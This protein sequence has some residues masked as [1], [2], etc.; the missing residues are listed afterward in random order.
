MADEGVGI[1]YP[2]AEIRSIVD[3]TAEFV[4]RN[5]EQFE[6]KILASEKDNQKFGFLRPKDPYAAYYRFKIK[7]IRDA[8]SGGSDP[9]Q[10][11]AVPGDD[12]AA[13]PPDEPAQPAAAPLDPEQGV[14]KGRARKS[15]LA[16]AREL[17][18]IPKAAPP[19]EVYTVKV[20]VAM[21]AQDLDMIKLTAQ[22]VARNGRSFLQSL[23]QREHRSPQFEFLKPMHILV[24][25][26]QQLVDAYSRVLIPPRTL[27]DKLASAENAPAMVLNRCIHRFEYTRRAE[28][29]KAEREAVAEDERVAMQLIDWHDFVVVETLTFNEDG[30]DCAVPLSSA[31]L[32]ARIQRPDDM[33]M[34][35][36]ATAEPP[37]QPDV[38]AQESASSV[39][40][41]Q[42]DE[43]DDDDEDSLGPVGPLASS[44][45]VAE[46]GEMKI[47][48]DYKGPSADTHGAKKQGAQVVVDPI[49]GQEIRLDEVQE[50][51]KVQLMDP[52][53]KE[54]KQLEESKRKVATS[55]DS[56]DSIAKNLSRLSKK[57][58]D[59]FMEDEDGGE[60]PDAKKKRS[61]VLTGFE[62]GSAIVGSQLGPQEG[63][64]PG[65]GQIAKAPSGPDAYGQRY[66]TPAA[67][68][69]ARAAA[70]TGGA[71]RGMPPMGMPPVSC[72]HRCDR[73]ACL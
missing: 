18:A 53:W 42:G 66:T 32:L 12:D 37:A 50:H 5:G 58:S 31:D 41:D 61:M 23:T 7:E 38:P 21:T 57:R 22:F 3:K 44:V 69:P 54:K 13:K 30:S 63:G 52:L 8:A 29:E 45:R 72:Q 71:P 62:S 14:V 49:T 34:D 11:A 47:R 6:S 60:E 43:E 48:K 67:T 25:F 20:P 70:A 15:Q 46:D 55:L 2:P 33:D 10:T 35:M 28:R 24:P 39:A 73:A 4:A 51:M 27:A 65:V 16:V 1:I 59:I 36:V 26:F 17:R 40:T 56:G 9:T 64:G 68:A 19:D